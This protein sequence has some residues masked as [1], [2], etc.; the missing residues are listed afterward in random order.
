LKALKAREEGRKSRTA[1]EPG[2]SKI[3]YIC[4]ACGTSVDAINKNCPFC[5]LLGAKYRAA[6]PTP[7]SA[8]IPS[9]SAAPIKPILSA[10]PRETKQKKVRESKGSFVKEVA[11][12][13]RMHWQPPP[14]RQFVRP[15]LAST[16]AGIVITALVFGG[17]YATRFIRQK[18][19][20]GALPPIMAVEPVKTYSLATNVVPQ[21]SG[22]IRITPPPTTNGTYK[23]GS[24][25][26]LTAVGSNCYGF[27]YW[28]GV[29]ASTENITITMDS[30]KTITANFKVNDST[31]PVIS[32]I[33]AEGYSDVSATLSWLTDEPATGQVDY[34]KTKEYGM[35][36]I[37]DAEL[38]TDHEIRVTG[39]HP[40]TTYY[41]SVKSA[42]ACG[43]QAQETNLIATAREIIYGEK[44]G[45]RAVDFTLPYYNDD[46]P[47]SPNKSGSE[48]LSS[49]IGKKK[50]LINFWSTFCGACIGE[51][52]YIRGVYEDANFAD[53]N[54]ANSD[55]LVLTVC[56]DSKIDEAPA[57]IEILEGKFSDQTGPFTFPILMDSVGQ[58]K[59]DY[60][61]WTIP[62]TVFIDSDG[63]IREIKIGRIQNIDEIKTILNSLN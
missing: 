34:G 31:P 28:G 56:T 22:K 7:A 13:E 17:I 59:K 38:D 10:I 12:A 9:S 60:H 46:N 47:E 27:S 62:E 55:F 4:P 1:E 41:F 24:Q 45:Q 42:D 52:P 53:R 58:T 29:A 32:Q 30:D 3:Q 23:A 36:A 37:S 14:L 21:D 2:E 25:V 44:V 50:I 40:N 20:S 48:T 5:G 35:S 49:Y 18:I 8:S 26:T 51:F 54:S 16:L 11:A 15:V 61:V 43:N 57:R 39:L 19:E 33:E 63:I 6:K